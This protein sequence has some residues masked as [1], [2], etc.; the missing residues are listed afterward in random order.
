MERLRTRATRE[1]RFPKSEADIASDYS[2]GP[3]LQR[4]PREEFCPAP[5]SRP[6]LNQRLQSA[7]RRAMLAERHI[8]KASLRGAA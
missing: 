2:V 4:L 6:H 7:G 3:S 5:G 1:K 8:G